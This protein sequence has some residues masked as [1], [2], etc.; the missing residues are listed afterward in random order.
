MRVDVDLDLCQAHGQCEFAAPDVFSVDDDGSVEWQ[1]TPPE[2]ER[3]AVQQ[4]V[5]LCPVQAIKLQ[6]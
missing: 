6:D 1:A 3:A 4:A 2:S 5:R